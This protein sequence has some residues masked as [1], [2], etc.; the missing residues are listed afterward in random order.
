HR[1]NVAVSRG[2]HSVFLVRSQVLTDFSPRS[3][4]ELLALGAFL[5]L[6]DDAVTT[7]VVDLEPASA[8][9]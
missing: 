3:P 6:G 4:E 7:E 1:L 8:G 9:A 2:Q 5:A